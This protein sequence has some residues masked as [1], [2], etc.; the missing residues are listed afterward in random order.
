MM[1]LTEA[2]MVPID[3]AILTPHPDVKLTRQQSRTL[4]LLQKGSK[5]TYG[6][7]HKTWSLDF[8]RSPTGL[9]LPTSSYDSPLATLSL[10]HT[11]VDPLTQRAVTSSETST[12]ETSLVVTSLGF[13]SDPQSS[14]VFYDPT[15]G[16][17][18]ARQG[19][20]VSASGTPLKNV[21]ASGWA[22]TGAKGV[23]ASTMMDAYAVADTIVSDL[24]PDGDVVQTT[25]MS[26][27]DP[28][29]A[30]DAGEM[31]MNAE[32]HPEDLP[33]EVQEGVRK[34][35]VVEYKDWKA[36]DAEEVRR[37]E[38]MGK[39]RERMG[40]EQARGFLGR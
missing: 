33:P 29:L 26:N 6:Q 18:R 38:E 36:I 25:P 2:S 15:A 20:V 32:A 12:L 37:G 21:Y 22:A 13:Q 7:T 4:Q 31:V 19:R 11:T 24:F 39:E 14:S 40:W 28:G 8:F 27:A 1:N 34:G 17:L 30:E 35:V 9:T 3:P 10:S 23:L 16:H 5:N